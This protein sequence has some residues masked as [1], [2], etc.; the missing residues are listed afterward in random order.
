MARSDLEERLREQVTFLQLSCASYD[1]GY[2]GEA[3]RLAVALRVLLHDTKRS[4]SLLTQLGLKQELELYD[5]AATLD[6]KNLV[7]ESGLTVSQLL[8]GR[9]VPALDGSTAD[10]GRDRQF[11]PFEQWWDAPVLRSDGT[12]LTRSGLMLSVADQDGGA[13]VDPTLNEA[14]EA[15]SRGDVWG[16]RAFDMQPQSAWPTPVFA[17]LRQ[18]AHELLVSLAKQ[19]PEAFDDP[20][21]A[22]ELAATGATSADVYGDGVFIESLT[23]TGLGSNVTDPAD[24]HR[25][26]KVGRNEPCPCGSGKKYKR[27]HG[28]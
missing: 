6:P 10:S 5:T 9:H 12:T 17:S 11:T 16:W 15:L 26:S 14:Y 20:R 8:Q 1:A 7:S 28:A 19:K 23:V 27:C 3:R 2:E 25:T 22:S 18:I 21:H 4:K 24:V 13:H